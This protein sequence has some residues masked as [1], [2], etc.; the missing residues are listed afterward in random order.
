MLPVIRTVGC[1]RID[2]NCSDQ[3]RYEQLVPSLKQ[4]VG[5]AHRISHSITARKAAETIQTY[6]LMWLGV[7]QG[8][9]RTLN[10]AAILQKEP[11]IHTL[12]S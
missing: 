2:V 5:R 9:M 1:S 3:E 4:V 11:G 7:F 6:T 8:V 10:P 12:N